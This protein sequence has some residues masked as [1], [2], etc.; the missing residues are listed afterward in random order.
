M[1]GDYDSE[2]GDDDNGDDLMAETGAQ[3][4]EKAVAPMP[5]QSLRGN[6]D[7]EAAVLQTVNVGNSRHLAAAGT[8]V[9]VDY[10]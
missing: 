3:Q 4:P 6:G 5:S 8:E 1:P 2:E 9:E 10:D 7:E